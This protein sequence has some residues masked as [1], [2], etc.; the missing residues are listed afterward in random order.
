[1]EIQKP[2]ENHHAITGKTH[3]RYTTKAMFNSKLLS[4]QMI[5]L[6][7]P[8]GFSLGFSH[9]PMGFQAKLDLPVLDAGCGWSGSWPLMFASVK[10]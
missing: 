8:T 10:D 9:F 2:M 6:H 3:Y 7:F 4:Y 1:M 5:N